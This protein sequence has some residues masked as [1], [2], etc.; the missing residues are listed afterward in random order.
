MSLK[1]C[2]VLID[3]QGASM[4]ESPKDLDVKSTFSVAYLEEENGS[5][6]RCLSRQEYGFWPLKSLN[7]WQ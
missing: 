1:L 5:R 2:E 3:L 7:R 4:R 6:G